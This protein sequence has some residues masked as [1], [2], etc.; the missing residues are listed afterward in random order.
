GP[1]LATETHRN[2]N[3]ATVTVKEVRSLDAKGKEMTVDRTLM[4]QHGYTMRGAKNYSSGKDVF[5]RA[6]AK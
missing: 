4:V 6:A 3:R 5:V 2:V 1:K